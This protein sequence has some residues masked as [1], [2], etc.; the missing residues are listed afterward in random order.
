M[1]AYANV[2]PNAYQLDDAYRVE[3]NPGIERFWPPWRHFAD[4][5]TMSSLPRIVQYRPLLPLTLSAN[6]ALF[7]HSPASYHAGN[8]AIHIAVVLLAWSLFTALCRLAGVRNGPT[9]AL[10]GAALL[11]VHPVAGIPVNYICARDLGLMLCFLL[12]SLWGYI[13][14]VQHGESLRRWA[15]VLGLLGL[16]L[17]AKKNAVVAPAL[18]L[19]LEVTI[20]RRSLWEWRVWRRVGVIAAAVVAVLL[21]IRYGVGFSDLG[22]VSPGTGAARSYA[23]TQLRVHIEHYLSN[24]VWPVAVRQGPSVTVPTGMT[25]PMV[26][27]GGATVLVSLGIAWWQRR[28]HPIAALAVAV[29]WIL[30]APT[31]SVVPTH[32]LA[33]HYRPFASMVFVMLAV[34]VPLAAV[35]WSRLVGIG[36]VVWLSVL[37]WRHS[38]TWHTPESLWTHSVAHGGDALAYHNLG[39]AV[40]SRDPKRAASLFLESL[41]LSPG[42]I[43]A[44]VN[45]GLVRIALGHPDEGVRLLRTAVQQA[46]ERAQSWYW[47]AVGLGRAGRAA[48]AAPASDRAAALAPANSRYRYQA[49]LDAQSAGDFAASLRHL[50]V[51]A[52]LAPDTPDLGFARGFALQ[53]LGREEE[54]IAVYRA[55]LARRPEHPQAWFNLGYALMV[56][57]R[58]SE[59]VPT[60][61][62]TVRLQPGYAEARRWARECAKGPRRSTSR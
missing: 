48:E 31:S 9:A 62:R 12:A 49:G 8:V 54:A 27:L 44:N 23:T 28:R 20:F 14:M 41:R 51:V 36:V 34:A 6:R 32:H 59:A 24:L 53:K 18:V 45:L 21:A 7:G 57:G 25:D 13:S 15:L 37:T 61:E 22:N 26:L 46:P 58:C 30:L 47:L 17:L 38:R 10:L 4:P 11:A 29:W 43:L 56:L 1:V 33:V 40:M 55:F 39:V 60:F 19:A 52:R 5:G 50:D 3:D 2:Y 16:S 35:R 42:Y